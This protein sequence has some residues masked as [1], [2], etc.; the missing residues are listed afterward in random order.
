MKDIKTMSIDECVARIEN[1]DRLIAKFTAL[2]KTDDLIEEEDIN[3]FREERA[4]VIRRLTSL[5]Y[6][7]VIFFSSY[8]AK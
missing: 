8:K 5:Q 6:P 3:Y 4:E 2:S 1:L 7:R